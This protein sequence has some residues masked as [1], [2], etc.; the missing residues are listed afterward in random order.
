MYLCGKKEQGKKATKAGEKEGK[1]NTWE[2]VSLG[3]AKK[4]SNHQKQWAGG[5]K[6]GGKITTKRKRGKK[7]RRENSTGPGKRVKR[8]T[9]KKAM[10]KGKG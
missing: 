2:K 5:G 7:K 9:T 6:K 8:S 3:G 10:V 4:A 1:K